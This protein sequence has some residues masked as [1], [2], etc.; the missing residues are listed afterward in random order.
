MH[1]YADFFHS[2]CKFQDTEQLVRY[3]KQQINVIKDK[4]KIVKEGSIFLSWRRR[5]NR[6]INKRKTPHTKK[7]QVNKEEAKLNSSNNFCSII[8]C[9]LKWKK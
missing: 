9:Y 6:P 4:Q 2:F 1:V 5:G 3:R 7:K 8:I